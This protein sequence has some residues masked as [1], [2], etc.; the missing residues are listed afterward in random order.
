MVSPIV[1][2]IQLD[3]VLVEKINADEDEGLKRAGEYNVLGL[4]TIIILKDNKEI[5]RL[6]GTQSKES[7]LKYL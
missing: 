4:L 1:D 3:D 2:S 6:N 5:Q 7:I